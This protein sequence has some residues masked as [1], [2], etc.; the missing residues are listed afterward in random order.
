MKIRHF[1]SQVDHARIHQAIQAAEKGTSGRMVIYISHHPVQDV[2]T[3]AQE[4]F[5]NLALETEKDRSNLL[6]F[7]AP[8]AKKFAVLGGTGL[9]EKLGQAW[10][11]HLADMIRLDFQKN[12]YTEGILAATEEVSRALKIHFPSTDMPSLKHTDIVEE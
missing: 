10:W 3:A 8:G 4:A 9:H 5:R 7:L 11:D 2:L 6:L 12:R 1:L